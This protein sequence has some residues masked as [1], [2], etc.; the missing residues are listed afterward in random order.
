M[1]KRQQKIDSLR[2]EFINHQLAPHGKCY[3]DVL[4]DEHWFTKYTTTAE[5]EVKFR[6]YIVDRLRESL[7]MSKK[8]CHSF[9]N[10]SLFVAVL[11]READRR[12]FDN[13]RIDL[14]YNKGKQSI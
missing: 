8:R 13:F 9:S 5:E 2:K 7:K 11:L 10:S 12:G 3:E 1:T 14:L 6:Q 4:D